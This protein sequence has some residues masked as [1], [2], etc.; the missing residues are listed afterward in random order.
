MPTEK[1]RPHC[2]HLGTFLLCRQLGT[3][4]VDSIV[5]DYLTAPAR[6]RLR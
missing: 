4:L 5:G 1:E 2:R 3:A 6:L